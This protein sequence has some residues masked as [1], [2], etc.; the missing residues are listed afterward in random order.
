LFVLPLFF[1]QTG[2][3]SS[4][5]QCEIL[6][7][8]EDIYFNKIHLGV[9]KVTSSNLQNYDEGYQDCKP[10]EGKT[11]ALYDDPKDAADEPC[12]LKVT[13]D[14][15]KNKFRHKMKDNFQKGDMVKFDY[16]YY[17]AMGPSGAVCMK[18]WR[19]IEHVPL[20]PHA[21]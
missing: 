3:A 2:S 21:R 14:F 19:L 18:E 7:V 8:V 13:A 17:Q 5:S 11:F 6:G 1:S 9:L 20:H 10:L 16:T 12:Q 4:Y 15:T